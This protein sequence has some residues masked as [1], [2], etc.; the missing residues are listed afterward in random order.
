MAIETITTVSQAMADLEEA[1]QRLT[2]F[3][4]DNA[5]VL[6]QLEGLQAEV[7]ACKSA[8]A[9]AMARDGADAAATANFR[10]K[11]VVQ[12]RGEYDAAALPSFVQDLPG[13]VSLKVDKR[14]VNGLV[15]AGILSQELAALA[16][17]PKWTKPY[18]QVEA[19]T[20]A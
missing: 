7:E 2:T 19:V 16:W 1:M 8:L 10:A 18:V 6:S 20:P 3:R 4:M 14:K 17:R 12:D 11:L 15:K 5:G 13:V 9:E